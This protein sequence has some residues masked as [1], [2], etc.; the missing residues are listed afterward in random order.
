MK[1]DVFGIYSSSAVPVLV[2]PLT[3]EMSPC[4][5]QVWMVIACWSWGWQL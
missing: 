1:C 4:I 3:Y 2:I 5:W